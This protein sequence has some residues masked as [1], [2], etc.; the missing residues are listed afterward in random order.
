MSDGIHR[1]LT[2]DALI[3]MGIVNA[4]NV[5]IAHLYL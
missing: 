3:A 1:L 2:I 5:A 4:E